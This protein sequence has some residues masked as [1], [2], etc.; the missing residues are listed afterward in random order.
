[1]S[2]TLKADA[3]KK[4]GSR[5]ARILRRQGRIP[6]SIQGEHKDPVHVSIDETEFLAARRHHEHLFDLEIEGGASETA[7]V[8]EL[9]WDPFGDAILHVEFRRVVR[10][11]KTEVEVEL[12]FIGHPR[13]GVLNHVMTHITVKALP[14]EIPDRIEV[15]VD[16]LDEDHS[17]HAGDLELPE[18][19]DL[20]TDPQAQVA[21]V[22]SARGEEEAAAAEGEE[23]AAA[24]A[25]A[26]PAA[27]KAPPKE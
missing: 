11:Q 17:L 23:G 15:K 7:V 16:G 25:P 12:E 26:A 4:V 27:P 3:R 20:V 8:N 9:H 14:S 18:G 10:G 24:A 5:F 22:V 13:G 1:M 21:N 19:V 6:A 2:A